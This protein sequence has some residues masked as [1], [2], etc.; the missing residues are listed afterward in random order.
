MPLLDHDGCCLH[1]EVLGRSDAPPLLL[2]MGLGLCSLAWDDLP[3][4]LARRFRVILL[5]NRGVGRST[6]AKGRFRI[7]DL[8]DD[9][10]KVLDA[11]LVPRAF[12]FGISMGGMIAQEIALRH[13]ER[14]RGLCLGA[15]F[16]SHW[17]SQKPELSVARDLLLAGLVSRSPERMARLLVSDE[18]YARNRER[19]DAWID[20]MRPAP[21]SVEHR[22]VAAIV[23]HEAYRRLKGLAI[24][25]LV[26][27]GDRDRLVPVENSRTLARIIPGARYVELPGAGHAFPFERPDET[28]RLLTDH[29]LSLPEEPGVAFVAARTHRAPPARAAV[30][31]RRGADAV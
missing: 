18:F 26:V 27:S 9:A 7:A 8:A 23:R 19:F 21:L 4:R 31:R 5:D 15:T 30:A 1:H 16:A 14:V 11:H 24:P 20:G 29:F 12:V 17:R 3:E 6:A 13:P 28:V 2:V 10:V 22:Q 25:T